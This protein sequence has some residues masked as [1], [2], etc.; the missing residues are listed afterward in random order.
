MSL[1]S[2]NPHNPDLRR[3]VEK[4]L[5]N[6]LGEDPKNVLMHRLVES[7][8]I[9][10]EGNGQSSLMDVE[11]ALEAVLGAGAEIIIELVRRELGQL[12]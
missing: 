3:A 1:A 12:W 8:R 4:A 9:S 7:H 10:F 2:A 5:D 6:I 11:K